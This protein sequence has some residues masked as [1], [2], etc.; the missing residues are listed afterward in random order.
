[1]S[2]VKT[3]VKEENGTRLEARIK[4]D[5][6]E[7]YMIEYYINGKYKKSEIFEGVSQRYVEDAASNWVNGIKVLKG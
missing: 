3:I 4:K 5:S 2:N 1:M 6:H 7:P